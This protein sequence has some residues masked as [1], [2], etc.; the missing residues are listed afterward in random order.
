MPIR[1]TERMHVVAFLPSMPKALLHVFHVA[2][3]VQLDNLEVH[4]VPD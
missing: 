3:L 4:D 2:H 1:A